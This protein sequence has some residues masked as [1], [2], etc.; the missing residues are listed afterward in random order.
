MKRLA[1]AL[2]LILVLLYGGAVAWL[3]VREISLVYHPGD[4]AVPAPA[5][6]LGLN[7]RTVAYSSADGTRLSAWIVPA[8]TGDTASV[9][10]LVCHGNLGN[11]GYGQR[12]EF[13]SFMRDLG[14]NVLAFDY[15]GFGA[16]E[17]E[18]FEEGLYE[19]AEASWR[20]L[21]DSLDVPP[22][23]IVIFGHSLG[24]G[25]AIDLAS[26]VEAGALIVEGAYTSV[27]DRGQE[28]YP[29]LP[30]RLVASEQFPSITKI[31]RVNVPKLF[32]HSPSD[33][34]IPFEHGRR[35]FDASAE[36]RFFV[37]VE[38]GH[39]NAYSV[40][41]ERYFSAIAALLATLR[42]PATAAR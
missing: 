25:V 30:V 19:D 20:F 35:L 17:G 40:D 8:A 9:W 7:Q 10:L 6:E 26:R 36:P 16:S 22:A 28:L 34:V 38:G 41:R 29:W 32:L 33:A 4:R 39:E 18:P 13:Y 42:S 27:A 11:I 15:R 31:A 14:V 23:N 3:K 37:A 1:A 12:P 21:R 24:S 2:G 5:A